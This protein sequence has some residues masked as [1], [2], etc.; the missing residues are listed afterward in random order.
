MELIETEKRLYRSWRIVR[1]INILQQRIKE[2][3]E[4]IRSKGKYFYV[5]LLKYRDLIE[6]SKNRIETLKSAYIDLNV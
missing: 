2:M 5:T 6:V 1:L 3:Q 4:L